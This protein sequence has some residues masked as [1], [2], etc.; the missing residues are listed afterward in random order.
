M[1]RSVLIDGRRRSVITLPG[2]RLGMKPA[3]YGRTY[4]AEVLSRDEISRLLSACSRR[5]HCGARN[6]A[7]IVVM[8]RAGLRVAEALALYRKDVDLEQGTITILHGKGDRRRIVGIDPQAAAVIEQW[9][10]RRRQLGL[11]PASPLFCTISGTT[12]GRPLKDSYVREA[13]KDLAH[14][15]GIEKRVHPHGLRHT[16]ASELAREGVPVHIIRRQLGHSS[17][18]TTARYIEHLSPWEVVQAIQQ[19]EWATHE[20]SP[21]VGE[22]ERAGATGEPTA[23]RTPRSHPTTVAVA[24]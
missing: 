12:R 4:P 20:P 18:A 8:W 23:E 24:A 1:P 16:H 22:L 11:G 19:R 9:I 3:N 2:Y 6:R 17:L 13:L 15:A 5:G 14:K 21:A 7:L 10:V